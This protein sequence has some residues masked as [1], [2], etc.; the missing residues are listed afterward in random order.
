MRRVAAAA[1]E[2]LVAV[3]LLEQLHRHEG[4]L[5]VV[6][7]LLA[8]YK[9]RGRLGAVQVQASDALLNLL[10]AA[11]KVPSSSDRRRWLLLSLLVEVLLRSLRSPWLAMRLLQVLLVAALVVLTAKASVWLHRRPVLRICLWEVAELLALRLRCGLKPLELGARALLGALQ[12]L[13]LE[14]PATVCSAETSSAVSDTLRVTG[15]AAVQVTQHATALLGSPAAA[16]GKASERVPALVSSAFAK[17][18]P[19]VSAGTLQ[20]Q[21]LLS[22]LRE[23]MSAHAAGTSRGHLASENSPRPS[24]VGSRRRSDSPARCRSSAD[25]GGAPQ[26]GWA[27]GVGRCLP[28][29]RMPQGWHS[30]SLRE[31]AQQ[32]Q[33]TAVKHQDF[34]QDTGLGNGHEVCGEEASWR[35]SAKVGT[36][37]EQSVKIGKRPLRFMEDSPLLA[38]LAST[39]NE[40]R[41]RRRLMPKASIAAHV[42]SAAL[43][44]EAVR[45]F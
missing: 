33:A 36:L 13:F 43:R 20:A 28:D 26:L 41:R 30:V 18:G 16:L 9:A 2:V 42:T 29:L 11:R 14:V 34:E 21:E 35:L 6:V 17:S 25:S 45:H 5:A 22:N 19:Y 38:R 23:A 10:R 4:L 27:Q 32:Q 31:G 8:L 39:L 3:L 24:A 12:W 37:F 7:C 1:R 40:F 15:T 44:A